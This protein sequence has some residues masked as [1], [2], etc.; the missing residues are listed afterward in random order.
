MIIAVASG[1]GGTG[2]TFVSA[3]L[4]RIISGGA[5]L[6]DCDVEEPN[7]HI[8]IPARTTSSKVV[9]VEVPE[10]DSSLCDGCGECSQVCEFNA[11]AMVAKTPMIFDEL[12]HA[13]GGCVLFCPRKAMHGK[14]H[15]IG[16]VEI[17]EWEGITLVQGQLDVGVALAVPLIREVKRQLPQGEDHISIVDCPPGTSC[18]MVWS[19]SDCDV[20][21]L[22]TEP[23][24][25]GLHDLTLAVDTLREV[26]IPF[27]VVINKDGIGDDRV[28]DYCRQQEIPVLARIPHDRRIATAYARGQLVSDSLLEYRVVFHNLLQAASDL[29]AKGGSHG[30]KQG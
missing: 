3:H 6:L 24:P 20:V 14:K 12:C 15:R 30:K 8:F 1:K 17:G 16:E 23:T 28:L 13:C 5:T 29:I 7:D 26:D 27:G 11:I 25:F 19:V 18:P 10:V 21:V 22:V 4:A 2:K 9:S